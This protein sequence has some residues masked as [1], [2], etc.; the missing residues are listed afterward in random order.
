MAAGI[1]KFAVYCISEKL[2]I[3][4]L[5]SYF[6]IFRKNNIDE[7]RVVNVPKSVVYCGLHTM[8]YLMKA[9]MDA[10]SFADVEEF[11]SPQMDWKI[12]VSKFAGHFEDYKN[13]Q[14]IEFIKCLDFQKIT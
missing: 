10:I 3:A 11:G 13:I 5:G 9:H 4:Q 2:R 1:D 6:S 14:C 7:W 8:D 12:V